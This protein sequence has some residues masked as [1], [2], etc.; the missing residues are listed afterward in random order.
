MDAG[1]IFTAVVVAIISLVL[2]IQLGT[3]VLAPAITT[4]SN[5]TAVGGTTCGATGNLSCFSDTWGAGSQA[6]WSAT[7]GL[8]MLVYFLLFFVILVAAVKMVDT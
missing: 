1:K 2:L 4:A 5:T 8:G 3:S 7:S 6:T